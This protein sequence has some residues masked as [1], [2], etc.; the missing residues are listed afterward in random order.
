MLFIEDCHVNV[1]ISKTV[2]SMCAY[3][4]KFSGTLPNLENLVRRIK[5]YLYGGKLLVQTL[6]AFYLCSNVALLTKSIVYFGIS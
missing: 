4:S 6:P 2:I 1:C 5:P 3:N